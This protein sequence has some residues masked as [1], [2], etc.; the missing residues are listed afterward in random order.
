MEGLTAYM[1]LWYICVE[2]DVPLSDVHVPLQQDALEQPAGVF[3]DD[4]LNVLELEDLLYTLRKSG[5]CGRL[6]CPC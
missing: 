6:G 1:F 3:G 2:A 5:R 4:L